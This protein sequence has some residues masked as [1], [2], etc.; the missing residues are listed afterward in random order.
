MDSNDC[1]KRWNV[2]I[3]LY[4]SSYTLKYSHWCCD[5]VGP[6]SLQTSSAGCYMNRHG[7][8]RA[9]YISAAVDSFQINE[10]KDLMQK[11]WQLAVGGLMYCMSFISVSKRISWQKLL[12]LLAWWLTYIL[13]AVYV[14]LCNC[15]CV[16]SGMNALFCEYQ[17]VIYCTL[18]VVMVVRSSPLW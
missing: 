17:S 7:G 6:Y 3:I 9:F 12:F 4:R 1:H 16:Q 5:T 14:S 2:Y 10:N 13:T 15:V 11:Q 18:A 8:V